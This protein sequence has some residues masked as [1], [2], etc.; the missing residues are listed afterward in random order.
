MNDIEIKLDSLEKYISGFSS[1]I[2]AFSGGVD[3]SFLAFIAHKILKERMLAVTLNAPF[4]PEWEV[5]EAC[6]LAEEFGFA[7]RVIEK[8]ILSYNKFAANPPDRCYYCKSKIFSGLLK[9]VKEEGYE[10]LFEGS[11]ADDA[12]TYRPGA[13]AIDELGVKSPLKAAG[14]LKS[15]IRSLSK[16]FGLPTFDKPSYACLASRFPYGTRL[17][18][19]GLKRVEMAEKALIDLGIS[20]HR[21]RDH[22]PIARVEVPVKYFHLFL[23]S[24]FRESAA[25]KL[26]DLGYSFVTL[27]LEGYRSGCFDPSS[28]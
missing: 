16:K 13:K 19:E 7:H 4:I 8:N 10:V 9:V 25:K 22:F 2:V 12:K 18:E 3:S 1:A 5:E 26:K 23:E 20:G 21:V 27:D 6:E 11:N 14:L 15:E 28:D 24:G 17:T